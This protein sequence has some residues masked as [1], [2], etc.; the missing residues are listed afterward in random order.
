MLEKRKHELKKTQ[1]IL[2][3]LVLVWM[4]VVFILSSQD[5]TKTLN[6]SGAF[7]N[8]I[9]N[10][11][12]KVDSTS[13]SKEYQESNLSTK[14]NKNDE[15]YN[16]NSHNEQQNNKEID[17]KQY[18]YSK[19]V[20]T[21][22]RKN[23]HYFLYFIGGI[24]LSICFY[25]FLKNKRKMVCFSLVT[26][27]LYAISDEF[28]QKFVSGRTSSFKDVVIDSAGVVTGVILVTIFINIFFTLKHKRNIKI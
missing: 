8:A 16:E 7:I 13:I 9:E 5:G 23:A 28:H 24:I 17:K 15:E 25:A 6:T 19:K 3:L 18:N 27:F 12:N 20:Q 2:T 10:I 14:N 1:V 21:L 26:G 4:I 11:I 22:T